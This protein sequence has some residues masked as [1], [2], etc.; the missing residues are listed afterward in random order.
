M[1]KQDLTSLCIH[2]IN[3]GMRFKEFKTVVEATLMPSELFQ[4][5]HLDWRPAA[6]LKKLKDR[7][8]FIKAKGGDELIPAKG[9]YERLAK[10][11]NQVVQ[12]KK[13]DPN[14]PAGN[15][16]VMTNKGEFKIS[17]FEKADLQT[18]KGQITGKVNVQPR[19]LG[20]T[21]DRIDKKQTTAQQIKSAIENQKAI[22][23]KDLY[24]TIIDN[25]ALRQAGLLGQAIK[26]CAREIVA[27]TIPDLKAYDLT[28][29][30]TIAIDAGEYLGILQLIH[31]T[32]TF[33]KRQQFLNFLNTSDLKKMS[34]IFPGAQNSPLEDSYGVQ[35]LNTGHTIMISS[36][37]GLG[38]TASGAAPSLK[39]L[40]IPDIM[41][42]KI[43]KGSGI[44][45]LILMQSKS[46]V[47]QPFEGFNFLAK[48][49]PQSIPQ[50]Y[51]SLLPFSLD[52][53]EKIKNNIKGLEKLPAKFN[54][55]IKTKDISSRATEGG[56]LVYAVVK[57]LVKIFNEQQPIKDFRQS[58]L[59]I[60]D[61][62]FV[63]IFSRVV[64]GKL[65]ADVL[66]P[67][68]VDGTV[69][70]WSKAEAAEPTKVGLSFKIL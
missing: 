17:D 22:L 33:P 26:K 50:I 42:K 9:E 21:A 61:L 40:K 35:N 41:K 39:G 55:I 31:E 66:W 51:N 46:S 2:S 15:F 11:I 70:L 27:K 32:A 10:Q 57:D 28:V 29:Q 64:G 53:I 62:N 4:I 37:G 25:D 6:F 43:K 3:I 7:T 5:K 48:H 67:G 19:G 30:K 36:K 45:F 56:K 18:P 68:K 14:A 12:A 52:D 65:T 24:Q 20:I 8:P 60:L 69:L 59:Q 44:D 49:Y 13:K 63:Q 34:I 1:C 58:V 47:E 54:K 16:T 38:K 23:G